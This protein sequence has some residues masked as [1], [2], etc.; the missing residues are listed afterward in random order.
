[1]NNTEPDFRREESYTFWCFNY[2]EGTNQANTYHVVESIMKSI[3]HGFEQS[4]PNPLTSIEN[5]LSENLSI[6]IIPNSCHHLVENVRIIHKT[7]LLS[8]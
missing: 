4:V 1:M 8:E 3:L 5:K 7:Q 6:D 2:I